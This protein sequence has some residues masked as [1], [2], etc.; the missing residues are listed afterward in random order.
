MF[1]IKGEPGILGLAC[2]LF[3][4]CML[5]VKCSLSDQELGLILGA[6][7]AERLLASRGQP[8][9]EPKTR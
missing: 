4:A 3:G 2:S 9:R 6:A 7:A 5:P 1:V 8:H